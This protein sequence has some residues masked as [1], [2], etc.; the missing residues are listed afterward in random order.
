MES[1]GLK[2]LHRYLTVMYTTSCPSFAALFPGQ[3]PALS[4]SLVG[5]LS[6]AGSC[7]KC[8]RSWWLVGCILKSLSM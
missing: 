5:S 1:T 7:P 3:N 4:V 6:N 2:S 8:L